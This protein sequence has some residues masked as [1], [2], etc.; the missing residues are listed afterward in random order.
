MNERNI[1]CDKLC[2][3]RASGAK[4]VLSKL[5]ISDLLATQCFDDPH[6]RRHLRTDTKAIKS[7]N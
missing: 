5:P 6:L 4:V 1:I 2:K 3:I 7:K